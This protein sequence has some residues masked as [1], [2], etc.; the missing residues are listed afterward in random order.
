[1]RAKPP[2]V[3]VTPVSRE[4]ELRRHTTPT[5]TFSP[6]RG[7]RQ[8]WRSEHASEAATSSRSRPAP[9]ARRRRSPASSPRSAS[10]CST[11][12]WSS[13]VCAPRS[14]TAGARRTRRPQAARSPHYATPTPSSS[15][16]IPSGSA[17][18]SVA[19]STLC[20]MTPAPSSSATVRRTRPPSSA[21]RAKLWAPLAKGR[22]R[23]PRQGRQLQ[24]R[25]PRVGSC[26]S[27]VSTLARQAPLPQPPHAERADV[28]QNFG[29]AV[30]LQ[31]GRIALPASTLRT[32]AARKERPPRSSTE[33][34]RGERACSRMTR[35]LLPDA[36]DQA[37]HEQLHEPVAA[38]DGSEL[39]R[40][41]LPDHRARPEHKREPDPEREP[42]Q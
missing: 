32:G 18:H 2:A 40:R 22:R 42:E 41:V 36:H 7:W 1:M 29:P 35:C 3:S 13:R 27:A 9:S 33:E 28:R 19:S 11:A 21:S 10:R 17:S 14:R 24:G 39:P 20:P 25:T 15:R 31:S 4:I 16:R 6:T 38:V 12:S 5:A 34:E 26:Y 8:R 30:R 23:C 37:D